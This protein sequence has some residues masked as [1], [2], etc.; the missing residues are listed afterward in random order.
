M[1]ISFYDRSFKRLLNNASLTI[2]KNSY[3]LIKKPVEMNELS[4]TCEPFTENIQPTF[5][6]VSD[7]LGRYL[8][9][10]LAG[11][12]LLNSQNKTEINGTDLKSMFSSDVILE[13][14]TFTNVNEVIYYL[15]N[16][17]N[18][19]VNQGTFKC[20]LEFNNN[21]GTIELESL[22]P[23]YEQ[24]TIYNVWDELRT[25]LKGYDLY[26][27]S[28]IDLIKKRV[29]FTIGKTMLNKLNI[30]LW[31]H[32]IKNYG[33]WVADIN[34]CQGFYHNEEQG[35]WQAGSKWILTSQNNITITE[36]LRDIFPIKKRIV[37]S[38][39]SLQDAETQAI[40]TL[41]DAL[42]NENI[43]I[44]T[45][46]KNISFET[47]FEVYVNKGEE[48]Y[49]DLPCGELHYNYSGLNKVQIGYRYTGIDFI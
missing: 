29:V 40:T 19:Q 28:R 15:F 42:Y 4:C 20:D 2:D 37:I 24:Y 43:E 47:R 14:K 11:I 46:N 22:V 5:L 38:T 21:V 26:I 49:K 8:Y 23:V 27:E 30:K 25:Y 41:L 18:T 10:S 3:S 7:D 31:E 48:K 44:L 9:G 1:I 12:P 39:E 13:N 17:W 16:E 6:V 45:D 35:L 34:E 32:G 33:K 36:S